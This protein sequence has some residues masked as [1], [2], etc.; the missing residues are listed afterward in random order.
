MPKEMDS[1]WSL[2]PLTGSESLFESKPPQPRL[3]N[4]STLIDKNSPISSTQG[5]ANTD[6]EA[7]KPL[8]S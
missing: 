2:A 8:V 5:K 4:T 7:N 3:T 6:F 1:D